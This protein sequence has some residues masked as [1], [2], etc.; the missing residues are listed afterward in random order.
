MINT[1]VIML[2]IASR[3][4]R[5]DN[6][7]N[8]YWTK[9]IDYIKTHNYNIK[10]FLIFGNNVN[11]SGLKIADDDKLILDV[12]DSYIPG[13]LNKTIEAFKVINTMY[14]YK[15][16][17]RTN[18]SSFFIIDN[19]I[20]ISN[21]LENTN[22]YAGV[23][24]QHNGI[25]FISGAGIWL[26]K[27]IVQYIIN[28]HLSIDKN[29]IDDVAISKLLSNHKKGMIHRYDLTDGNEIHDKDKL[30][31]DIIHNKYYHIRIISNNKEIDLAYMSRFT[32]ILYKI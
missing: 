24:G 16:I 29:I 2:V 11:T 17:I 28:N 31:A 30:I 7:I 14:N 5:Y 21:D 19:L 27:D 9:I 18:L 8:I 32:D 13:I 15:H 4:W 22:V 3:G 20:K 6:I 26:S 10:I 12:P 23:N 25:P 1:D